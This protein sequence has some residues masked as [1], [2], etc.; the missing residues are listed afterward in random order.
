[1]Y[2]MPVI[3]SLMIWLV[4]MVANLGT[5]ATPMAS[6]LEDTLGALSGDS[7]FFKQAITPRK[8]QV[9]IVGQMTSSSHAG[10]E[11]FG[12]VGVLCR[13]ARVLD[14]LAWGICT[15]HPSLSL[16]PFSGWGI[17]PA[18]TTGLDRCKTF[19]HPRN[20]GALLFPA[21]FLVAFVPTPPSSVQVDV[22]W[23]VTSS[24]DVSSG[25]VNPLNTSSSEKWR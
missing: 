7:S 3:S 12:G 23:G 11:G 6:G 8:P 21:G 17:S 16:G 4:L 15:T 5:V 24:R 22:L 19:S 14:G 18:A 10:K 2:M 13:V 25:R 9:G 20:I 1:M